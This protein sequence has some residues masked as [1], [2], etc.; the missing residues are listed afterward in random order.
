MMKI[1]DFPG[2][3]SDPGGET[4]NAQEHAR[5][6]AEQLGER[7][8]VCVIFAGEDANGDV[9]LSGTMDNAVGVLSL[10]THILEDV[11][12]MAA[13]RLPQAK[14]EAAKSL[15]MAMAYWQAMAEAFALIRMRRPDDYELQ[16]IMAR[17][18]EQLDAPVEEDDDA[19]HQ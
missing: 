1:V 18:L 6:I 13:K 4:L 17:A 8:W 15:D 3:S 5:F 10:T 19:P 16:G 7:E 11:V 14:L 2:K 12:E 9:L